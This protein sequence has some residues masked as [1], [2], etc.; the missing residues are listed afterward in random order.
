MKIVLYTDRLFLREFIMEDAGLMLDLNSDPEVTRYT[1]DPML[2]IEQAR[3]V[4]E[5]I[6][7]PQYALN[8][9][10][11]WAVHLKSSNEF[12]GWCG[13]K[14]RPGWDNEIDLGY[15]FKQI[16]WGKGYATEAAYASL[17]FGFEKLGLT[18][19]VGRALPANTGS[20]RVLEKLGMKYRGEE[21]LEG[22]LHKTYDA[23]SHLLDNKP[24]IGRQA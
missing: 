6:I 16:H 2:D 7:L 24:D 9:F 8:N 11:R 22:L 1:L 20:L 12:I 15:R 19:I 13:L 17:Q 5:Q 21:V 10:G 4:L 3:K 14:Y 23:F 18:H